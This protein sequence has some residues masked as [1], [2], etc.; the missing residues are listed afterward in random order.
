MTLVVLM[1]G[2]IIVIAALRN[3]QG[4]LASALYEDVPGFLVWAAAILA[5]GAIGFIPRMKPVSRAL[6]GLVIT[7]LILRNYKGILAGFQ[8]AWQSPPPVSTGTSSGS[9]AGGFGNFGQVGSTAGPLTPAGQASPFFGSTLNPFSPFAGQTTPSGQQS[10]GSVIQNF[11]SGGPNVGVAPSHMLPS[12]P[13][14]NTYNPFSPK[15]GT[16]IP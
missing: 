14:Y 11:F 4:A 13:L 7:V 1:I 12:S 10:A 5:V 2:A 6:L 16:G 8:N 3:S 15:A 9:S